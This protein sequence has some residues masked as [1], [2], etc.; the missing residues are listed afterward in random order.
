MRDGPARSRSLLVCAPM[1][2]P[3]IKRS[4]KQPTPQELGAAPTGPAAPDDPAFAPIATKQKKP[5]KAKKAKD[6]SKRK[7]AKDSSK[8]KKPSRV[9]GALGRVGR[10]VTAPMRK[11]AGLKG[12][13][14]LVVW[15]VLAVLIVVVALQLRGGRDDEQLVRDALARFEEASVRK[16]YQTLCDELFASSYV[17]QT[18]SSG[19]PCE[20]ALRTGLEDVRNPTLEV[21]S[22]EVNGDR[23]AARVRGTAAGQVPAEDVYTLVREDGSWRILPPRPGGATP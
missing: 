13:P 8:P 6:P 18:A 1:K 15:G 4:P 17:R 7:M 14:R 11:I 10:V 21:V 16:D 20:V 19:L 2:R 5:K 23:A 12:K 3:S 22:V 9:R